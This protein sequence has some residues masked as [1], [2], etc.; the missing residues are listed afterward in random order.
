MVHQALME[1]RIPSS[2]QHFHT[3]VGTKTDRYPELSISKPAQF[4]IQPH[5]LSLCSSSC[6]RVDTTVTSVVRHFRRIR[7][8]SCVRPSND[9][10]ISGD[11]LR[12][13]RAAASGFGPFETLATFCPVV[14]AL[15]RM[16]KK[17]NPQVVVWSFGI[18]VSWLHVYLSGARH[19]ST[20]AELRKRENG[21]K[22][23]GNP[24]MV[25]LTR[26]NFHYTYNRQLAWAFRQPYERYHFFWRKPVRTPRSSS[27][28][29]WTAPV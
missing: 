11:F 1:H 8:L 20:L 23:N 5:F 7:A 2:L 17:V 21:I 19:F 3:I 16:S 9:G 29:A 22:T 27:D 6:N 18:K 13:F 12:E 24:F 15:R 14:A 25:L 28:P 4:I 26:Q 10:H